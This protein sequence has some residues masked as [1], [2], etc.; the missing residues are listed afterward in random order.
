MK[1]SILLTGLIAC[2]FFMSCKKDSSSSSDS[3]PT[4]K[5]EITTTGNNGVSGQYYTAAGYDLGFV[6][7][8]IKDWTITI[9]VSKPFS[10]HLLYIGSASDTSTLT[11]SVNNSIVKTQTFTNSGSMPAIYYTIN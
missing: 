7:P 1:K 8:N 10:A 6:A 2:T 3:S 11:I 9:G 4:V 5:Y